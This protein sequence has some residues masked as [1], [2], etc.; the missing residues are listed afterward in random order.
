MQYRSI[1]WNTS[2]ERQIDDVVARLGDARRLMQQIKRKNH[3]QPEQVVD[4]H[5][6]RF[7]AVIGSMHGL[8]TEFEANPLYGRALLQLCGRRK[9]AQRRA[10][11]KYFGHLVDRRR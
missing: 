10:I 9:T 5:F 4:E 6:S 8:I 7:E 11:E 1:D 2:I 3:A